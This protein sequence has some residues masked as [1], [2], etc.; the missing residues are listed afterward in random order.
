MRTTAYGL[1]GAAVLTLVACERPE[2]VCAST[3]TLDSVTDLVIDRAERSAEMTGYY[4]ANLETAFEKLRSEKTISYDLI[5]FRGVNDETRE[6]SC[7][8]RATLDKLIVWPDSEPERSQVSFDLVY[9]QQ[10]SANDAG[11]VITVAPVGPIADAIYS[12]AFAKAAIA[13]WAQLS[14]RRSGEAGSSESTVASRPSTLVQ[15]APPDSLPDADEQTER[16]SVGLEGPDGA[17]VAESARQF[18][19]PAPSDDEP[20]SPPP[21]SPQAGGLSQW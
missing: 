10:P 16:P 20:T 15:D 1:I 7:A 3:G 18:S 2:A 13:N 4:G 12:L 11:E 8:A 19:S 9:S 17:E 6:V 21:T 14:A 5:V